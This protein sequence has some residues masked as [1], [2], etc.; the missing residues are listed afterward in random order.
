MSNLLSE[1]GFGC[2]YY[3][4]IS[5]KSKSTNKKE[6][7]TK[8][9]LENFNS[10]NEIEIGKLIKKI[11]GYQLFFLPVVSN[12][13]INVRKMEKNDIE[14]DKCPIIEGKNQSLIAM[15]IPYVNQI[16]FVDII[17]TR[18]SNNII[19]TIIE[20]YKYLLNSINSL[21]K[22]NIVHFDLKLE[23]ILFKDE[24]TNPRI[25][26]F[27]ISIPID[28]I[29]ENNIKN[30]FYAYAPSYYIWCIDIDIICYLLHNTNESLT[31]E[32]A[33]QIAI[34]NVANNQ[35]LEIFS[36]D[37]N[38]KY[39]EITKKE[40]K[41]YVGKERNEVIQKLKSSYKTWDNYSLSI[42]YLRIIALLFPND[43]HKNTLIILFS[44]L[45][46]LNIHPD[47][48]K[49]LS[50]EETLR[51]FGDIFYLDDDVE[52]YVNLSRNFIDNKIN[53]TRRIEED[54]NNLKKPVKT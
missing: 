13:K 1:G 31:D 34:N 52:S 47:P 9:Q 17:K 43:E 53:T 39:L 42:I 36:D 18:S 46:L 21:I 50:I 35:A 22:I 28:K 25:I 10:N 20:S 11:T 7:V 27:G 45:L 3:P 49:R 41:K 19:L 40:V 5:C 16:P 30:Y 23:N 4:G 38:K 15:D 48:R 2:I 37:F 29:N 44:Q 51:R 32:E 12:C 54:I 8:I 33:E 14:I 6:M 26:D 24:T